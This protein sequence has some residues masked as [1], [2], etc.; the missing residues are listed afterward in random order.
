MHQDI[1]TMQLC[2]CRASSRLSRLAR[3]TSDQ[4][5][6]RMFGSLAARSDDA[7]SMSAG[8]LARLSQPFTNEAEDGTGW[9]ATGH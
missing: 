5:E 3:H 9:S 1:V 8:R 4:R 2:W 6:G 7:V